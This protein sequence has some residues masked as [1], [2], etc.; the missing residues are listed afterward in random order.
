MDRMDIHMEVPPVHFK[1]L[2]SSNGGESSSEIMERVNR[3]REI[4][5]LRLERMK[6]HT[7][8]HMKSREIRK[9]CSLDSES[10]GLLEKAMEKFGLSANIISRE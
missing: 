2:S 6:I 3:A 4:Q 8:A 5:A 9:F 1:D 7:N 10:E